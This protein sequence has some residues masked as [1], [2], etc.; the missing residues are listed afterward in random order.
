MPHDTTRTTTL[1]SGRPICHDP[2]PD[3]LAEIRLGSHPG[4][5]AAG[6]GV[7]ITLRHRSAEGD[8]RAHRREPHPGQ[9]RSCMTTR[10]DPEFSLAL[11]SGRETTLDDQYMC[12]TPQFDVSDDAYDWLTQSLFIGRGRLGWAPADRVRDLPGRLDLGGRCPGA[13]G[14]GQ[15]R[16]DHR[17][18]RARAAGPGRY[19]A[20]HAGGPRRVAAPGP[21]LARAVRYVDGRRG[22]AAGAGC[23]DRADQLRAV[24]CRPAA[25]RNGQPISRPA[26]PVSGSAPR[27]HS[28]SRTLYRRRR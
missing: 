2:E 4:R 20:P 19:G 5:T 23:R 3:W 8:P 11:A 26:A 24:A 22:A 14:T 18:C 13:G 6:G 7:P 27:R 9:R 28:R 1:R 21:G 15:A 25:Y 12:M 16:R 17:G 10:I